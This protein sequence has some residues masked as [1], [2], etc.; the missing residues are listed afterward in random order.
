MGFFLL[1]SPRLIRPLTCMCCPMLTGVAGA[2]SPAAEQWHMTK[3][4]PPSKILI[5]V[6]QN[7][8]QHFV[9]LL[10]GMR[11]GSFTKESYVACRLVGLRGEGENSTDVNLSAHIPNRNALL[12]TSHYP[13]NCRERTC[14]TFWSVCYL[15]TSSKPPPHILKQEEPSTSLQEPLPFPQDHDQ[16]GEHDA[17]PAGVQQLF[18]KLLE[19]H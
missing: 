10:A 3:I 5:C 17:E 2:P 8:R 11:T 13:S 6:L 16:E 4:K 19:A 7:R 1:S 18:L 12:H 15:I 14:S 9:H